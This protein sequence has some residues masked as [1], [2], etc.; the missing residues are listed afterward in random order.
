MPQNR[1]E[2]P[3]GVGLATAQPLATPSRT[4]QGHTKKTVRLSGEGSS[5]H[6]Q[7]RPSPHPH[8][9]H[10]HPCLTQTTTI[11]GV[12]DVRPIYCAP[13]GIGLEEAAPTQGLGLAGDQVA[14]SIVNDLRKFLHKAQVRL[15]Q[16]GSLIIGYLRIIRHKLLIG[17]HF[18]R[19]L[20][21]QTL[22]NRFRSAIFLYE[23]P[24][25]PL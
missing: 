1:T 24:L 11:R 16:A 17:G 19:L 4:H 2:R 15:T 12:T 7:G 22:P 10:A 13:Q 23:F 25:K 5:E 9:T 20:Q 8:T 14:L 6:P 21:G 18:R 3:L